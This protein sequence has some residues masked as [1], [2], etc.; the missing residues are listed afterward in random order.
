ML[1][2][3]CGGKGDAPADFKRDNALQNP[4]GSEMVATTWFALCTEVPGYVTGNVAR[5]DCSGSS[6][7]RTYGQKEKSGINKSHAYVSRVLL[8]YV[9]GLKVANIRSKA[10]GV[11]AFAHDSLFEMHVRLRGE[12]GKFIL[13]K[14]GL[15]GH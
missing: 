7:E 11:V 14:P 6:A 2:T 15:G 9:I 1:L 5:S 12:R 8:Y 13:I 10:L 3:Q 4:E